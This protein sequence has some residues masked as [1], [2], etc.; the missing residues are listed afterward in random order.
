M[1][2]KC[3]GVLGAGTMG[4]GLAQN[5][6]STGHD[7]I[8]IDVTDEAL[9]RARGDIRNGVRLSTLMSRDPA[10]PSQQA[11]LARIT[12]TLDLDTL[13]RADMLIENVPEKW[14]AK[15]EVYPR[16][17]SICRE[18]CVFAANT[19]VFPIARLAALTR[20]SD[21]VLGMHFM[22]PV[23]MKRTVEVVRGAD[24]SAETIERATTLLASL[25]KTWII[26]NDS[27]G[28]VLNR[29]LMPAINEAIILL[30]A[31]V[32]SASDIDELF[33]SCL[34]H[35]MGPLETADL[36]GLDTV[37]YS[38]EALHDHLTDQRPPPCTLLR[39]MVDAGSF[40]RKSGRGF[41][42]YQTV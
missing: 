18:D 2:I 36:I 9:T 38:I 28:F 13:E 27:P 1:D 30:E 34:G 16:V 42:N 37:L 41:Y 32:A 4:T 31:G 21:R 39:Q 22:T 26:V 14:S 24:T 17:D 6:A 25:G 33:K 11:V 40:G 35:P 7:V 3:V 15:S 5:L 20:R 12:F 8:L 19:S 10:A 23:P 29:V